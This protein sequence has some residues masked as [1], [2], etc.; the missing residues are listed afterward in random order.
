MLARRRGRVRGEGPRNFSVEVVPVGIETEIS[1]N[2]A[3]HEVS[4]LLNRG[5]FQEPVDAAVSKHI[6]TY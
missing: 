1:R 5:R 4:G 2:V 6:T 3:S